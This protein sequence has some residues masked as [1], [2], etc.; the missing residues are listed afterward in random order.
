MVAL[1]VMYCTYIALS[2]YKDSHLPKI[3]VF[4]TAYHGIQTGANFQ[5]KKKRERRETGHRYTPINADDLM[6]PI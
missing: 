4:F 1:V 3:S 5:P 6:I 2:T